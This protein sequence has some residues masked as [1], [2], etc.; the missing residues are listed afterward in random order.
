MRA[1]GSD[2]AAA[3]TI[4]HMGT[5]AHSSK[6]LGGAH[7]PGC[8]WCC[9][10]LQVDVIHPQYTSFSSNVY[11]NTQIFSSDTPTCKHAC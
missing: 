11:Y 8:D 1:G 9:D 10:W 2:Q 4:G 6:Q 7:K 5:V 3:G